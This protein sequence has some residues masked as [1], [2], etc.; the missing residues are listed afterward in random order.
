MPLSNLILSGA[1]MFAGASP[2][3]VLNVLM[4]SKIQCFSQ[5]T[6]MSKQNAYIVPIVSS[7]WKLSQ[8][9]TLDEIMKHLTEYLFDHI[10][11]KISFQH[12]CVQKIRGS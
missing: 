11:M 6:Y 8:S 3:T 4:H 2:T 1:I 10:K 12:R 9:Y 7:V 5:R